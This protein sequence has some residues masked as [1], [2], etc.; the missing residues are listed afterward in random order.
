ML[1]CSLGLEEVSTPFLKAGGVVCISLF[2]GV[3]GVADVGVLVWGVGGAA[4][5]WETDAWGEGLGGVGLGIE[6]DAVVV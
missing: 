1:I 2:V 6:L 4:V 5:G 3:T